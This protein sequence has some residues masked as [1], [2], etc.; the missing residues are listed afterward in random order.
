MRREKQEGLD[1]LPQTYY[2]GSLNMVMH[3]LQQL[4]TD[5]SVSHLDEVVEARASVLEASALGL[6]S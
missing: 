1:A 3:E 4:P 2:D 6:H 5:F